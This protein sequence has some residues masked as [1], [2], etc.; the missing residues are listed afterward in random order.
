MKLDRRIGFVLAA[1]LVACMDP[2]KHPDGCRGTVDVVVGQPG[3]GPPVFGWAPACGISSLTVETVPAAGGAG[4]IVWQ[5]TAPENAQI[6]PSVLYGRIPR[7]AAEAHA[8]QP[9][10][11]NVTYRLTVSSTVGGD[12]L[13]GSGTI[14]FQL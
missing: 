8:A 3:A 4:I 9:L 5:L 10:L 6:G 1:T 2:T 14:T 7:G 11:S 12:V 13:A